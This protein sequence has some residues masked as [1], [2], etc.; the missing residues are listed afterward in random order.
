VYTFSLLS[1]WDEIVSGQPF[2][3]F[4]QVYMNKYTAV[5]ER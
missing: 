4:E 3:I 5:V 2:L 1:Q